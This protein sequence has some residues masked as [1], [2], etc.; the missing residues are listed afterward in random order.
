MDKTKIDLDRAR[1]TLVKLL[2]GICFMGYFLA[3]AMPIVLETTLLIV[4]LGLVM[5]FIMDRYKA[6][7]LGLING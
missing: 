5:L 2:L 3:K 6:N 1:M 4:F 7:A